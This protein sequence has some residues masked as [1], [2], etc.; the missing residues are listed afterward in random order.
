M[1]KRKCHSVNVQ[2]LALL[3]W[4]DP[5]KYAA[6]R[7]FSLCSICLLYAAAACYMWGLCTVWVLVC[8]C[9]SHLCCLNVYSLL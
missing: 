3:V 1:H 5:E 2:Y 9:Y 4:Q 6:T 8:D 7:Y